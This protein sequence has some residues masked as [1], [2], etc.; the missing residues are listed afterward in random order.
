MQRDGDRGPHH[1]EQNLY[2][3]GRIQPL[4]RAHE[5]GKR[6][7]QDPNVLP[8]DEAGIKP[9]HIAIGSLDQRFH[10]TTGNRNRPTVLGGD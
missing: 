9:R 8:F 1:F 5:I 4:E 6:P 3:S 10:D 7:G 2:P